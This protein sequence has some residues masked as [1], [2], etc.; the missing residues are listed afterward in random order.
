MK[1]L[2]VFLSILLSS[3]VL[4]AYE[5]CACSARCGCSGK[6]SGGQLPC[7]CHPSN[8]VRKTLSVSPKIMQKQEVVEYAVVVPTDAQLQK[9]QNQVKQLQAE[10]DNLQSKP[11]VATKVTTIIKTAKST[12]PAKSH[13]ANGQCSLNANS[14]NNNYNSSYNNNYN[15][16]RSGLLGLGIFGR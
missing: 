5:Q 15:N 12:Q 4:Q 10:L 14:N 8:H 1:K 11:A 6:Y 2:F 16:K 13:C 7:K 9:L 3:P